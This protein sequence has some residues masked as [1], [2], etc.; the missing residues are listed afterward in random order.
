MEKQANNILE[1]DVNDFYVSIMTSGKNVPSEFIE[2]FLENK[3]EFFLGKS[4]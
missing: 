3:T 4:I 2:A 1:W